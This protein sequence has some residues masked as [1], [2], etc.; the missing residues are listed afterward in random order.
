VLDALSLPAHCGEMEW[1][2]LFMHKR[3]YHGKCAGQEL[4]KTTNTNNYVSITLP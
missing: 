3:H 2:Y 1:T 4:M